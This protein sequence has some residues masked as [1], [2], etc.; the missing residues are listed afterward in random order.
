M[1]VSSIKDFWIH[2]N[3]LTITLNYFGD[4]QLIQTSMLAGSVILAYNKNYIGYDAAHNY[5]EWKL[6]T[7]PTQLNDTCAYYVHAEL[8]RDGDTAMIIYSPVKRD[9]EGRRFIDGIW[10]ST[11]SSASWF[12]YLGEI[13]ASVDA[14]GATVERV[15]TD[16]LYTGTLATDQ[17]RLEDAQGDWALMFQLN[18][19]TG[20]IDVLKTISNATINAINIVSKIVF[21]GKTIT[22]IAGVDET[23]VKVSDATLPTTAYTSKHFLIKD[24]DIEQE[25]KGGITFEKNVKVK[26]DNRIEGNQFISGNQEINSNQT[27]NGDNIVKGTTRITSDKGLTDIALLIGDYIEEGDIIQGAAVT[28]GGVASFAKVKAPSMQIYE[29]Y[30]NRKTAVQGEFIFSDGDTVDTVTYVCANGDRWTHQQVAN[31]LF[32]PTPGSYA[33]IHLGLSIPYDGYVTSFAEHDILYANINNIAETGSSAKTG[34]CFMR[35]LKD[36]EIEGI[37]GVD[38]NGTALNVLLYPDEATPTGENM[39]PTPRMTITRHGNEVNTDRQ[40]IFIISSEDGRL[41]QLTGV[42]SPIIHSDTA[43]GIVLGR[44]PQNLIE[45]IKKAGY[46]YLNPAQPYLYARGAVIQ[47]LI[48]IDYKGKV[49]KTQ[50]Y[51]GVWVAPTEA[52]ESQYRVTETMYDTV[53]HN[54]SLWQC[55]VDMTTEEPRGGIND[56][57]LLVAK[58]QDP[59]PMTVNILNNTSFTKVDAEG[60]LEGWKTSTTIGVVEV[61]DKSQ[62]GIG[63]NALLISK[64]KESIERNILRQTDIDLAVPAWY[65]LSFYAKSM[66]NTDSVLVLAFNFVE[67]EAYINGERILFTSTGEEINITPEWEQYRLTFKTTERK[68]DRTLGF[69][70]PKG[71]IGDAYSIAKIKLEYASNQEDPQN[72]LPS[73]WMESSEDLRGAQG[74]GVTIVDKSILY[75]TSESGTETPTSGWQEAI[76]STV[77]GRYLWSKTTVVY[78]DGNSTETYSVSRMG[79]DGKGIQSSIVEYYQSENTIDPEDNGIVWGTFPSN[80][81]DGWWLYTRTTVIYSDGEQTTSYDVTQIGQGSYYAGL[82]EYYALSDGDAEEKIPDG[83]PKKTDSE[84]NAL[85]NNGYVDGIATYVKGETVSIGEQWSTSRPAYN[86][87]MD[88]LWNFSISRDSKGN[89]YVAYPICIGNFAKG[90]V[91]VK[92][93]YAISAYSTPN[94]N[95][96]KY[97][98]DITETDWSDEQQDVAPTKEK[99]YQW[100][101]TA[102][103]YNDGTTEHVYHVSAVRGDDGLSSAQPN[104]LHN[105]N[106]EK[107]DDSGKLIDF[108]EDY[109]SVIENGY[110]GFNVYSTDNKTG[111]RLFKTK[112]LKL[113]KDNT[114]TFSCVAKNDYADNTSY[115]YTGVVLFKLIEGIN[116]QVD[117]EDNVTHQTT[118]NGQSTE[119]FFGRDKTWKKRTFTFTCL[120]DC[121]DVQLSYYCWNG[122]GAI[123][124]LKLEEGYGTPYTKHVDDLVA[125]SAPI[126]EIVPSTTAIYVRHDGTMTVDAVDVFVGETTSHGYYEIKSASELTK[127]GLALSYSFDG[128][129]YTP[130]T[131]LD[132]AI[133]VAPTSES[134]YLRLTGKVEK[135]LTIPVVHQGDTG[136][137]GKDAITLHAEPSSINVLVEAQDGTLIDTYNTKKDVAVYARDPFGR[138]STDDYSIA[139]LPQVDKF[140]FSA[141]T[142]H[143]NSY[144]FSVKISDDATRD[145]M[146]EFFDVEFVHSDGTSLG[147]LP[148]SISISE[149][150]FVGPAGDNGAMLLPYGYWSAETAYKL[151]RDSNG[152]VVGRPLVYHVEKGASK[153]TYFVLQ[154]DIPENKVGE[155]DTSNSEYWEPFEECKAIYT[156][157]LMA[158]YAKFGDDNG[159]IFFKQFLF[160][161]RGQGNKDY[162]HF[163]PDNSDENRPIFTTNE[164]GQYELSGSFNPKLHLDFLNGLANLSCLCEPYV[165]PEAEDGVVQIDMESGFNIKIPYNDDKLIRPVLV[166]PKLKDAPSWYKNGAHVEIMYE[167]GGSDFASHVN[168]NILNNPATA[169]GKFIL[170]CVDNPCDNDDGIDSSMRGWGGESYIMCRGKRAKYLILGVGGYVRF[171]AVEVG[172]TTMWYVTTEGNVSEEKVD[173]YSRY[174]RGGLYDDADGEVTYGQ[175]NRVQFY[176]S[177]YSVE[178]N[179][180]EQQEGVACR[181]LMLYSGPEGLCPRNIKFTSGNNSGNPHYEVVSSSDINYYYEADDGE[182]LGGYGPI[183]GD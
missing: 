166:L 59:V 39:L 175:Y 155:V 143:D 147:S 88:Y 160:S 94:V 180:Q 170:I 68:V 95:G 101:Q 176:G 122:G 38:N 72:A 163:L 40:D 1:A 172:N 50:N 62:S 106:F 10:D 114:Y 4:P 99:P 32:S 174:D 145:D 58:G 44:L 128:N 142:K 154:K 9:I 19:A 136:N 16:G 43:Y 57:L 98:N 120:E 126:Y 77:N 102:T 36:N 110:N 123:A 41:A 76:P 27:I 47:D 90:I 169:K 34:K 124:Q 73:A 117:K 85:V 11:T 25:V 29:L 158:D 6:Q 179:M 12:I 103:T 14:E 63:A 30:Y 109:G 135:N 177:D 153:G 89:Q 132:K 70:H 162:S 17:Q 115:P 156:E 35:V 92:E 24:Q 31:G 21:G 161:Q 42:D 127:K 69:G 134:L 23:E 121:A 33:Y 157:A 46:S 3:A 71:N 111:Q 74:N 118:S 81:E 96:Q 52:E 131:S 113:I 75:V 105:T 2:P 55:N 15:W 165:V 5:R 91:D 86:T 137:A 181:S 37:V 87:G 139:P 45:Y 20:L 80:L 100:N 53:T 168:G 66:K 183:L 18:S 49:I 167:S 173:I 104:L 146:P 178:I 60:N 119:L 150:G 107:K 28:K 171:R 130:I 149:R 152:K 93:L 8:S 54:G 51:R 125:D 7:F 22:G 112:T 140:T 79:V 65:T 133:T 61:M 129:S 151:L 148:I 144:S 182:Y 138:L 116:I 48:L 83:Y 13:S 159:A 78:S 82:Q 164:K 84:G 67:T 108:D 141:V 64:A 26:G 97:P 56:W